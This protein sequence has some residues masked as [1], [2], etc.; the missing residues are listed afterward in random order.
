VTITVKRAY[1]EAKPEDGYRVLVDRLWPRGVSKERAQLD[2][3]LKEVAP[4]DALRK[5]LHAG[6]VGWD[7]FRERYL[8]ELESHRE[9]LRPLARRAAS[10]RVTLV[11]SSRSTE[12]NNATVVKDYLETLEGAST[13]PRE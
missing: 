11:F 8:A 5:S 9:A 4:S 1:E 13:P 7:E 6:E 12:R 2:D 10:Q 3:W